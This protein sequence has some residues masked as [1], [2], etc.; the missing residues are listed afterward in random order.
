MGISIYIKLIVTR[1]FRDGI[2]TPPNSP[3]QDYRQ[4]EHKTRKQYQWIYESLAIDLPGARQS[5][6]TAPCARRTRPG[7]RCH[8]ARGPLVTADLFGQPFPPAGGGYP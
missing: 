4:N 6:R 7:T 8:I 5:G 2:C 3:Y 1:S